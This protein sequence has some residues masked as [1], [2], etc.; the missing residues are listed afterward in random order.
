MLKIRTSKYNDSNRCSTKKFMKV[1]PRDEY[2]Q[3]AFDFASIGLVRRCLA[4]VAVV[5]GMC[6][7]GA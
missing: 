1:A 4:D 6:R 7:T 3:R 2:Q 5:G